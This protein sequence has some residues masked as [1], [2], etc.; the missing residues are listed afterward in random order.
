LLFNVLQ[1]NYLNINLIIIKKI[2]AYLLRA[3]TVEPEKQLMLGNGCVTCKNGVTVGSGVFYAV[4]AS[5]VE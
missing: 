4:N 3:R 2:V 1:V 5:G